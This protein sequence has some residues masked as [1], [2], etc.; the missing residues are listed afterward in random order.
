MSASVDPAL[1]LTAGVAIAVA[2]VY[3]YY[4]S[5]QANQPDIHP[6][7]LSQQSFISR[8]RESQH[9]SAVYRSKATP[10]GVAL[11]STP[12]GEVFTLRDLIRM[13][14]RTPRSDAVKFMVDG[15]IQRI[16]S[17]DIA[18][19]SVALAGG[20][21]R[22][23]P[24]AESGDGAR[25]MAICIES[26]LDF[27][28][29]YQAC[30]EAGIVAILIPAAESLATVEAILSDSGVRVLIASSTTAK[31]FSTC[32]KKSRLTHTIVTGEFDGSEEA[33]AVRSA[34]KICL[35]AELEQGSGPEQDPA[36]APS[37]PAYVTYQTASDTN[38]LRGVVTTHANALAA[39]AGLVASVPATQQFSNKDSFMATSSMALAATVN[40]INV[41]LLHGCSLSILDTMDA[42]EF[43]KQ[44][45]LLEPTYVH[46][47]PLLVRDL[48]QLFYSHI[49]NYPMFEHKLFTAGYRR[50]VD[51]LM[52]GMTPKRDIWDFFY[53]R[54]YR[55]LLGGKLR[56]MYVDGPSTPS[57]SIE[58]L[59]V[60]HGARVIPV[61][62]AP[63][64]TAIATAGSF[65]DYASAIVAHNVGAPLACNEVKI[66]DADEIN[67]G[68]GVALSVDPPAVS[69]SNPRGVLAV[70]GPSVSETVWSAG[71]QQ[72]ATGAWACDADGWLRLPVYAEILP[73]GT[74]DIIGTRQT[75]VRSPLSPSGYLFVELLERVLATSRAITD[76]CVVAKPGSRKIGIVAHP[77]PMELATEARRSKREYKLKI[78]DDYPW[79]AEYIRQKLVETA[80]LVP[81]YQWIS[82]VP[83]ADITVKLVSEPFLFANAMAFID[84]STNRRT[85]EKLL[86]KK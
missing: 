33:E 13:G 51:S 27:L 55:N 22:T 58:W 68:D 14:R 18:M 50:V 12:V 70:R 21:L 53:F 20:L 2:A 80:A 37:D 32:F 60:L 43:S 29:A 19:R 41:A 54:H 31:R 71:K 73:N 28:I 78:I 9:E 57:K 36:I 11:V 84:G 46:L 65:Y 1:V 76:V 72:K 3:F 35:L 67:D 8:V 63:Q 69:G 38:A 45:Y 25:A 30:I 61:F 79:T 47:D 5:P 6:L 62:G 82:D 40:L 74:I 16:P 17:E 24:A 42:E 59:R 86:S 49:V 52:R 64:T 15:K 48:V 23:V 10:E 81:A 77:R 7:Q 39:V 85:A 26:S 56:L 34:T 83:L 75:V 4:Y 66:V 44:A